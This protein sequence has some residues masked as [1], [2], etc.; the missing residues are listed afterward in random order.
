M[1]RASVR[2]AKLIGFFS[3]AAELRRFVNGQLIRSVSGPGT[4]AS[5]DRGYRLV[6]GQLGTTNPDRQFHGML[7]EIAVYQRVLR[8]EEISQQYLT[9]DRGLPL[10]KSPPVGDNLQLA[11]VE[12]LGK[13]FGV[14]NPLPRM[15]E[16]PGEPQE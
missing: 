13:S 7:D 9:I 10:A 11:S 12:G 14:R 15:I 3:L 16:R 6:L 1:N 4:G 5:D 2:Y 8:A